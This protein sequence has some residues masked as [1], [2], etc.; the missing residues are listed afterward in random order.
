M[1][2]L[3]PKRFNG[4]RSVF[5]SLCQSVFPWVRLFVRLSFCQSVFQSVCLSVSLSFCQSVFLSFCLSVT[6]TFYQFV[7]LSVCLSVNLSFCQFVFL[8]HQSVSSLFHFLFYRSSHWPVHDLMKN[9]P[10]L[11]WARTWGLDRW[12]HLFLLFSWS[13]RIENSS[14]KLGWETMTS[15]KIYDHQLRVKPQYPYP[16]TKKKKEITI[17]TSSVRRKQARP[18]NDASR[19][20]LCV[21]WTCDM[22][23][24]T[25]GRT[26]RWNDWEVKE[27]LKTR[28]SIVWISIGSHRGQKQ[29]RNLVLA[30]A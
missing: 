1:K 29:P 14:F 6:L 25:G 13:S 4:G 20:C 17:S 3:P 2:E 16:W 19:L 15:L 23:G 5:W 27:T 24:E 18:G 10:S 22:N 8:S 21:Y 28:L 26:D 11:T 9:C 12:N 30:Q 7:F